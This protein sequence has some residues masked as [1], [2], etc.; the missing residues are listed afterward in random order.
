L[1]LKVGCRGQPDRAKRA[2]SKG[3]AILYVEDS[4]WVLAE[5]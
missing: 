1:I 2:G 3:Y 4:V 5:E